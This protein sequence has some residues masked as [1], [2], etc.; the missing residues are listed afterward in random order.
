MDIPPVVPVVLS[1]GSG[2]RLWPASRPDT[3]KQLLALVDDRTM[4][5]ATLDRVADLPEHRPPIVVCGEQQEG[6]VRTELN[7]AGAA[8]GTIVVEPVARNTAPATAVAALAAGQSG[9]DPVLLVM[10]ADHIIGDIGAF[11]DVVAIGR[12]AAADGRLVTFGVVPDHPATGYG[13]VEMGAA[14]D[15]PAGSFRLMRFV[16]KP[17][18]EKA[19]ELLAQGSFLWNSGMFMFKA[20]T[21]LSELERCEGAIAAACRKAMTG[22]VHTTTDGGDTVRLDA[23]AFA[24]SPADSVDYAVM[25]QTRS[26]VVIPLDAAWNDIGSWASLHDVADKDGAG[27]AVFGDVIHEGVA[28]SYLRSEG[29]LLTVVGISNIVAVSTPDAVLVAHID[30]TQDV[31]KIVAKLNEHGRTE[32]ERAK[33]TP[34]AWGLSERLTGTA[35]RVV[36]QLTIVPQGEATVEAEVTIVVEGMIE[37]NGAPGGPGSTWSHEQGRVVLR[38]PGDATAVVLVV[39]EG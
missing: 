11:H 3:P 22:A 20:S 13:Y 36:D 25:E 10:P 37:L 32:S 26:G 23:E 4:L 34:A 15:L 28:G 8:D 18:R 19:S 30:R 7:L 21:Y 35:D 9:D 17:S 29:P 31:R 5:H 6:V 12:L 2:T 24:D 1:G 16:E 33:R 39:H 14:D 27:N 38:N